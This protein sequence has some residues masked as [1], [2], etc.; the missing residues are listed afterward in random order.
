MNNIMI[1]VGSMTY[2]LK[3]KKLLSRAGIYSYQVKNLR[4]DGCNHGVEINERDLFA[5]VAILRE[6]RIDYT[7]EVKRR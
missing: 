5:A 3:L 6:F 4:E 1:S 7:I 2:A